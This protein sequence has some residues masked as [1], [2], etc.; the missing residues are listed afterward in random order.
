MTERAIPSTTHEMTRSVTN[1]NG[2]F[3]EVSRDALSSVEYVTDAKGQLRVASVKV[4]D[5]D[6]EQAA[7]RGWAAYQVAQ[8]LIAQGKA[9]A[10]VTVRMGKAPLEQPEKP[11]APD[12][13]RRA[14]DSGD[15]T[16]TAQKATP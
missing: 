5:N 3:T 8:E 12:Y 9:G 4:Y 11:L 14:A 6:P 7:R 1:D 15:P 2:S 10:E 13:A 16:L